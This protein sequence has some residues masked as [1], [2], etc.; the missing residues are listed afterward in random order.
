LRLN[1]NDAGAC[2]KIALFSEKK[3]DHGQAVAMYLKA[4]D[5]FVSQKQQ[6]QAVG[7]LSAALDLD[8]KQAAAWA[9]RGELYEGQ[10]Q[11]DKAV[12]DYSAAVKLAPQNAEWRK[13]LQSLRP[14]PAAKPAR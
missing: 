4:A 7:A 13:R 6:G 3:G 12:A 2:G 5:L 14:A 1:P 10:G 11:L 9:R 8:P